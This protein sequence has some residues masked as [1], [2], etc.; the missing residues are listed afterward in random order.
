MVGDEGPGIGEDLA[1]PGERSDALEKEIIQRTLAK[2]KGNIT[3][4]AAEL[5]ISRPTLH[6]LIEKLG[7]REEKIEGRVSENITV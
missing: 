2:N 4:T 6:G 1:G 7:I 5:G 3:R